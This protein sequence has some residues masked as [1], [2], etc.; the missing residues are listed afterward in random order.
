MH[1]RGRPLAAARPVVRRGGAAEPRCGGG[2]GGR[3]RRG[4]GQPQ[5]APSAG[6]G[7]AGAPGQD[8]GPAAPRRAGAESAE[9]RGPGGGSRGP[10]PAGRLAGRPEVVGGGGGGGR[11]RLREHGGTGPPRALPGH[12]AHGARRRRRRLRHGLWHQRLPQ[13]DAVLHGR[14]RRAPGGG[15]PQYPLRGR[16]RA[17]DRNGAGH[18]RRH[19]QVPRGR[20][21]APAHAV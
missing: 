17:R 11:P 14:P 12:P 3:R 16:L 20:E 4:A 19:H 2:E 9:G 10:A 18:R 7:P 13:V 1:R 15:R 6:G 21:A 8:R 5:G